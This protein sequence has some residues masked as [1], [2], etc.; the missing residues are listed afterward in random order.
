M[1]V[2]VLNSAVVSEISRNRVTFERSSKGLSLGFKVPLKRVHGHVAIYHGMLPVIRGTSC[3][4]L[5]HA[6]PQ[7]V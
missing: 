7:I 3:D 6:K 1:R 5:Q 4:K 2:G